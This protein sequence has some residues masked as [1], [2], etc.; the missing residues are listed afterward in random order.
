MFRHAAN[1]IIIKKNVYL[2]FTSYAIRMTDFFS[3]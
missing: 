3:I 1:V 2:L